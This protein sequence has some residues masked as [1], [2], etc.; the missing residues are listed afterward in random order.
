[1]HGSSYWADYD[2]VVH[3]LGAPGLWPRAAR[4]VRRD[5]IDWTGLLAEADRLSAADV[6]LVR[7]AH[8]LWHAQK[9][10]GL[11]EVAR[12]LDEA[13]FERVVEALRIAQSAPRAAPLAATG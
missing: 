7:V 1:M 13:G 8:E 4:H 6:L 3:V 5:D 10:V 11:W 12:K 9:G 2:A